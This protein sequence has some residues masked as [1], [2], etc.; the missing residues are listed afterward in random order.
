MRTVVTCDVC[1]LQ[2]L[3][4]RLVDEEDWKQGNQSV[5]ARLWDGNHADD[6]CQGCV[7]KGE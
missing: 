1:G 7:D 5:G 6:L 2:F 4:D 3:A